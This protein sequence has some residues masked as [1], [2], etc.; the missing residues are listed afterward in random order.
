[1]TLISS[2]FKSLIKKLKTNAR[3]EPK[4]SLWSMEYFF[5]NLFFVF[6]NSFIE[7]LGKLIVVK[8]F[9]KHKK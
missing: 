6:K 7:F 3:D 2:R 4:Y 8:K 9:I 1:M 5:Y